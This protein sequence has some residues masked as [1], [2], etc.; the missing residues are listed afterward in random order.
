[1]DKDAI[2]VSVAVKLSLTELEMSFNK[3]WSVVPAP[4]IKI[5]RSQN[6]RS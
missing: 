6:E 1:M 5:A 2:A 4:R 3:P